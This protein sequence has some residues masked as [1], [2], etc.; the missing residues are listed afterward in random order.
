MV[1]DDRSRMV[2]R[3]LCGGMNLHKTAM[4]ASAVSSYK[5][6]FGTREFGGTATPPKERSCK[7]CLKKVPRRK[8][9]P[10]MNPPIARQL[11]T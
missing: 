5:S 1:R 6:S 3:A 2:A 9:K 7:R 8:K 10:G 4:I 11:R